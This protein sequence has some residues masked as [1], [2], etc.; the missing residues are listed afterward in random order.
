[1]AGHRKSALMQPMILA[2]AQIPRNP[3]PYVPAHLS[4]PVVGLRHDRFRISAFQR[5][6]IDRDTSDKQQWNK[7]KYFHTKNNMRDSWKES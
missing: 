4:A 1:M 6:F 5:D 3:V 2:P 7:S